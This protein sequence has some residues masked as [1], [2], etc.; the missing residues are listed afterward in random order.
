MQGTLRQGT[1]AAARLRNRPRS[2]GWPMHFRD[3]YHHHPHGAPIG[4]LIVVLLVVVIVV[5]LTRGSKD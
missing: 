4:G 3:F 2:L 1:G 5:V